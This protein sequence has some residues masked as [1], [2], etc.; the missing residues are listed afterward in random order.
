MYILKFMKIKYIPAKILVT[1]LITSLFFDT[2][3]SQLVK[4]LKRYLIGVCYTTEYIFINRY[5]V[6]LMKK[7][8]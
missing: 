7:R 8:R 1:H 6:V 2:T 5:Q 4:I 3:Y